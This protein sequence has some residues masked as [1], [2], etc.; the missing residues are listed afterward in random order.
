MRDP[1]RRALTELVCFPGGKSA[2]VKRLVA[3]QAA[4]GAKV[5]AIDG[6]AGGEAS[7]VSLLLGPLWEGR[8]ESPGT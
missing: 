3:S 8:G 7:V 6:C 1:A 5:S 4:V 2:Y